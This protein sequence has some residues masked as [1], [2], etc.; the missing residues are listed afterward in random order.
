MNYFVNENIFTLNSG[1]EFSAAQ[2]L[3]LFNDNKTPA[4]LMTRNYNP[5]LAGDL[6]R[7]GLSHKNLLNMY[8]YFQEITDVPKENIDV[9]YTDVIDKFTYHIEGVDANESLIKYH[10]NTIGKVMIAPATVGL[11]GT[12][13]YYNVMGVATVRDVWD[14]RGFKSSTQYIHPDGNLGPQ[15][16]FNRDGQPKI[17]LTHM[18][19]NG[20]LAS[21]MYKL[22]D[23]KGKTWR[24]NRE[25]D[26]FVFFMNEI[27]AQEEAVFINDRPSL[28]S[29]VA[30]VEG[31]AGKWQ[32]LHNIHSANNA[33]AGASRKVLDYLNP[34]FT[35]FIQS[36]DGVLVATEQQ[37]EEIQKYF[38]FKKV[39]AVPD[40]FA[41]KIKI[42]KSTKRDKNKIVYLG[43]LADDKGSRDLIDIMARVHQKL[44]AARLEVYG[45]ASPNELQTQLMEDAEKRDLKLSFFPRGYQTP[46]QLAKE[47][48]TAAVL[49]NTSPGEGF[50]MNVLEGMAAGVPAV[51]YNVKYGLSE[52]IDN[53]VNGVLVPLRNVQAAADAVVDILSDDKKQAEFSAAA[54]TK[55]QDF[56]E[57]TAWQKWRNAKVAAD[58]LFVG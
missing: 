48:E 39:L 21:T 26:L 16:F 42:K 30:A 34:L 10:G 13:E 27:A 1:T 47:L 44:P 51:A 40:S 29:A 7:M 58:N 17:E 33:Q 15:V 5:Q 38:Q 36:F 50:G 8:D 20:V 55:A 12:I 37:K 24:F 4:K 57:A 31:A 53:G 49:V 2:R 56:N 18:N 23:Y 46:A 45:Y 52:L 9:R 14:R 28:M 3:Q 25:D 22:L 41:E 19:I 54:Y 11:V 6:E 32:Y 43:R 35:E